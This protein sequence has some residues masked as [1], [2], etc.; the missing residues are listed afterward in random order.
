[1]KQKYI[2]FLCFYFISVTTIFSQIVNDGTFKIEPSTTVYFGEQYTN[3]ATHDN[4]GNLHL[5]GNFINNGTTTSTA[6]TTFF[7]SSSTQT[8]TGSSS[9]VSFYNLEINNSSLGVSV[10]DNFGLFV[11]NTVA[12][13]SG[14]LRLVNEAQLIQTNNVANAGT[15][16]LLRDQQG[17]SSTTGYNYWASPVHTSG[18]F[19]LNGG[20][21][22]GTDASINSFTPQQVL[23]NSGTPYNGVPATVDGSG[24]VTTP[25]AI[26]TDWLYTYPAGVGW[27]KIDQN[28]ALNPGQGFSMKGTGAVNQN[29]VFKGTPNNGNYSFSIASGQNLLIG[30]PYPSALDSYQFIDDNISVLDKIEF[31][32]DGGSSS[33]YSSDYLGGYAVGNK[34]GGVAASVIASISGLGTASGILPER[35]IAVGQGFFIEATGAGTSINFNN[36]QRAFVTEGAGSSDFYK[37]TKS[38]AVA[39]TNSYIRVGYEDPEGFHRQLLLGFLPNSEANVAYNR[40]YDALMSGPREDE[41]FFIIENNLEKKY[42]IQGVGA[43]N[44]DDEFPLG[45]IITE[46]GIHKI[47]IDA[48]E[49]FSKSVYIKDNI[50]NT[51]YNIS[52]SNF[53]PN[54]P[55]GEYLDRFKLV[56]N[57]KEDNSLD[58]EDTVAATQVYY[59]NKHLIINKPN[60]LKL[61]NV[62]IYNMLGQ[63]LMSISDS[64]LTQ[65]QITIPFQYKLGMYLVLVESNEGNKAFKI[66]N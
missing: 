39:E 59:N 23:F 1:M 18:T 49:N 43:F 41:L 31:W 64:L 50:L 30:N 25:L 63:Q 21:F 9:E 27:N 46:E 44:Q 42:V 45:L 11:E 56:F 13:T 24:N 62:H 12:L 58:E 32:V 20:L 52:T 60:N 10:V 33:H 3:N 57:Q 40:G 15:G 8:I 28:T 16:K 4:D 22:D 36:A 48:V 2:S 14:D 53:T 26:T 47:M 38:K 7:E 65:S 51:T 55:P 35:Y 19:S 66:I 54:L 17:I 37:T 34:T 5:K 29:Y 61:N 6:G